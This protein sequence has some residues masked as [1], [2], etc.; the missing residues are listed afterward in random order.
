[1]MIEFHVLRF[2]ISFK[3]QISFSSPY[4]IHLYIFVMS[5]LFDHVWMLS[6]VVVIRVIPVGFILFG[7][8]ILLILRCSCVFRFVHVEFVVPFL[9]NSPFFFKQGCL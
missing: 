8:D 7:G 3:I 4:C 2:E 6:H 9:L 1:M 5:E